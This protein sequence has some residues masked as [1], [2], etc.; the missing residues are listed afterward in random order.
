M[1]KLFA[2]ISMGGEEVPA[3]IAAV[4]LDGMTEYGVSRTEDLF[5][6]GRKSAALSAARTAMWRRLDAAGVKQTAVAKAFGVTKQA[7]S[8]SL[9][10][11]ADGSCPCC[12]RPYGDRWS[13]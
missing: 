5:G 11:Q 2:P 1:T 9:K 3:E 13:G 12:G 10:A 4:V 8:K 6:K 7:V